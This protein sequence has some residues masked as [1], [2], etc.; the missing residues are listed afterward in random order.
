MWF[1]CAFCHHIKTVIKLCSNSVAVLRVQAG[2]TK[3]A[4]NGVP[5]GFVI[6]LR[7]LPGP[8]CSLRVVCTIQVKVRQTQAFPCC[9]HAWLVL[10]CS[11]TLIFICFMCNNWKTTES[12]GLTW[13]EL[14]FPGHLWCAV[15]KMIKLTN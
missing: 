13:H 8:V 2:A 9:H 6:I 3:K 11:T 7:E 12:A 5:G 15:E 14:Y 10:L 4:L 1:Q